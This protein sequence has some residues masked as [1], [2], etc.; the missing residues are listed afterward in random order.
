[1]LQMTCYYYIHNTGIMFLYYAPPTLHRNEGIEPLNDD[2]DDDDYVPGYICSW[3]SFCNE[4][5]LS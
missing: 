2:D 1:M 3:Q 4:C 5:L